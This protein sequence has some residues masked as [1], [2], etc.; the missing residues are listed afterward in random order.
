MKQVNADIQLAKFL[1]GFSLC[2]GAAELVWGRQITGAL[3]LPVPNGVVQAF[4]AREVMAG[5]TVL[6]HPDAV[7][8][9]AG[10]IGG[11]AMNVAVLGAALMGNNRH[12]PRALLALAAVLGVMLL[13]FAAAAALRQRG[14]RA[15]A[16]ARRTRVKS[17]AA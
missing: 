5:F 4:G 13:D 10:R 7:T 9:I 11:D 3:G 15:L 1:G 16:T 6:A 12:R 17:V 2:L 14:S 8:P